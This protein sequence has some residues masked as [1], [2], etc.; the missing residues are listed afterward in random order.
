MASVIGGFAEGYVLGKRLKMDQEETEFRRERTK[1]QDARDEERFGL[2]KERMEEEKRKITARKEFESTL[3]KINNDAFTGANGFEGFG[4]VGQPQQPTAIAGPDGQAPAAP[5]A[6]PFKATADGLYKN[7]RAAD[8]LI[9]ERKAA[10]LESLYAKLGEPEKAAT[11]RGQMADLFEKDVERKTK[12]A[13]A[14]VALGAPGSM[15]ALSK[16]YS[17]FND[18]KEINPESGQWDA[19]TKT[20]KGVEFVDPASGKSTM[21]D[22][23]QADIMGLAKRDAAALALFN[24]EQGYKQ[25][26]LGFKERSTKADEKRADASMVTANASRSRANA[27]NERERVEA[28]GTQQKAMVDAVLKQF[29]LATKEFKEEELM[30]L[31]EP[32]RKAKVAAQETEKRMATKTLDLAGLNPRV[33]VRTLAGIARQGKVQAEQDADGRVFTMIGS[34]KVYL[35]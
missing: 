5:Q 16:V 9:A 19:K 25:Q 33:D 17:Y 11:V 23:T 15:Q 26:E 30:L 22:V 18:G 3:S 32:E 27:L 6:N 20:W 31:K 8:Q 24:I 35:K 13:L 4:Y 10:A 21:R 1:K 28:N 34:T 7:Q 29:P 2:E 12:T 14:A